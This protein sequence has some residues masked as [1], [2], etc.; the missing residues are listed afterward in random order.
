MLARVSTFALIGLEAVPVDIEVDVA[1]GLPGL[2]LVG[3]PDQAVKEARERVRS[4]IR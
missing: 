4:A 2:T 3:L 1:Q